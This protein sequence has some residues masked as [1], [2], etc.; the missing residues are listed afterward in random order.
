MNKNSPYPIKHVC[1]C[2]MFHKELEKVIPMEK[3]LIIIKWFS[4]RNGLQGWL[5]CWFLLTRLKK[6]LPAEKRYAVEWDYYSL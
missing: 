2:E 6:I 3:F 1:L 4:K 5:Y